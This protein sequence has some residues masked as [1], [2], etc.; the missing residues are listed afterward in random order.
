MMSKKTDSVGKTLELLGLNEGEV[1][2]Y[3]CLLEKRQSTAL[4]LSKELGV[5]R[6]KV[7]RILDSLYKKGFIDQSV[8]YR[9][10][11]F[12]PQPLENLSKIVIEKESEL[13]KL[14]ISLPN[15]VKDLESKYL[16]QAAKNKE[17][18]VLYFE[19]AEGVK[20]VTWNSTKAKGELLL[21]EQAA[22][23][24]VLPGVSE[25]FAEKVRE[26]LIKNRES[27]RQLTN[28]SKFPAFTKIHEYAA[29]FW[30]ARYIPPKLL[31]IEVE[32]LI[33]NDIVT[34]YHTNLKN[35]FCVEIHNQH[36]ADMQR[37][38]FNFIWTKAKKM[39]RVGEG[40]GCSLL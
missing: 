8:G 11:S 24:N 22:S 34:M 37:Q 26:E 36:L 40:G 7:Y 13:E 18:K 25:G 3:L 38:I 33:Y 17:Y 29:H 12:I 19:G 27:T 14:K 5:A 21:Y 31:K 6:T 2:V 28:L 39:K 10:S 35:P 4:K 30:E 20:Q 32:T 1:T 23:M 9:G 16:A 15:I